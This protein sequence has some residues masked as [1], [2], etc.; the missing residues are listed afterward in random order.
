MHGLVAKVVGWNPV[1]FEWHGEDHA[2][3]IPYDDLRFGGIEA[4]EMITK[5]SRGWR[6]VTDDLS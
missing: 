4:W 1:A 5:L 3:L 2:F 6:T